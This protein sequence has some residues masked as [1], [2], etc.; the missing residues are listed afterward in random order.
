MEHLLRAPELS[1]G[2]GNEMVSVVYDTLQ[3]RLLL[4]IVF[5]TTATNTVRLN[6]TCYLLR[7][8]QNR[9]ILFLVCCHHFYEIVC[10]E[11]SV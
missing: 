3:G 10:R 2:I 9:D 7:Q 11:C 4:I 5:D 8:K 6:G 1:S